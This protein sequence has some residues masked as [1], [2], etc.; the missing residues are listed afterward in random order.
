[1]MGEATLPGE[2]FRLSIFKI[3]QNSKNDSSF[4]GDLTRVVDRRFLL[5]W[6]YTKSSSVLSLFSS[7]HPFGFWIV[8]MVAES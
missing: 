7:P 5:A 4:T 1:M 3:S 8:Y 2:S 6:H